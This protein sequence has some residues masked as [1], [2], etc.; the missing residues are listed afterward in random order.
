ML[1]PRSIISG[2]RRTLRL[3]TLAGVVIYGGDAWA[4]GVF[5]PTSAFGPFVE[6]AQLTARGEVAISGDTILVSEGGGIRVF[7]RNPSTD[8]WTEGNPLVPS[9]AVVHFGRTLAMAG[10]VAI[11][12][13]DGAAYIYER[14]K[15]GTWREPAALHASDGNP[16][17]G[18]SVDVDGTHAI[19]GTFAPGQA[20]AAYVFA[21]KPGTP[22][23]WNET[24]TLEAGD[25]AFGYSVGVGIS[26][27]V[28][29]VFD[30]DGAHTRLRYFGRDEG[31]PEHWGLIVSSGP[32]PIEAGPVAI[33][34]DTAIE[35]V[36][37]F[38]CL[39]SVFN[40]NAGGPDAWGI[41]PTQ[42]PT[43]YSSPGCGSAS[44]S[45][46]KVVATTSGEAFVLAQNQGNVQVSPPFA[47]P[48]AWGKTSSFVADYRFWRFRQVAISGDTVL[49]RADM[50][51]HGESLVVLVSDVDGD[52]IRDGR[53]PC[54]RDPLNNV[55]GKC[56][57]DSTQYPVL[58]D[59]IV[60]DAVTTA[61]DGNRF[62]MSATF[63]NTSDVAVKNPFFEVT[64]LTGSHVLI[65]SD[66]GRGR[67]GATLSPDVGDGILSPGE[68]MGADFVVD[69]RNGKPFRLR[70]SFRG[71]PIT[72]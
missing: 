67:V 39:L 26:G 58:D 62:T 29:I 43:A 59:V 66:A 56:Q 65:N 48:G 23:R 31:G 12:G 10:D 47:G 64:E 38:R 27:D 20:G 46:D 34:G 9:D 22:P 54:P 51:G 55:A 25:P 7:N 28:A 44:V 8:V 6:Q 36:G 45:G 69:L 63:T 70:V 17:F 5:D 18:S 53:D 3:L 41:V 32:G 11:V 35:S 72:P 50:Y 21:R 61:T 19:V 4:Q 1:R 37:E 40:R 16:S 52:G 60:Q 30:A 14:R 15:N 24:A 2:T 42:R 68:S 49:V 71:E 57:R 13:A 33:D